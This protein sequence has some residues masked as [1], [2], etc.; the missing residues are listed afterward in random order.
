MAP[1]GPRG[2][3]AVPTDSLA[4]VF[5]GPGNGF[6]L[7]RLPKPSLGPDELL[8]QV[9]CCTV[10][11][12]DLH[13]YAG[14]RETPLP[15]ILGHE[16][17]GRI[18]AWSNAGGVHD[19]A[20]IPLSIG[21]RVTW[22]IAASCGSCFFCSRHLPQ[23]CETLFKYGHAKIDTAH[24]LSGGFAEHCHLLPGTAI[25]RLPENLPDAVAAPINCATATVAAALRNGGGCKS[26]TV[27]VMGAG[28][29]GLT[30][31]AMAQAG[32]ASEIIACDIDSQRL[33]AAKQFG[34]TQTILMGPDRSTL[35]SVVL[36]T[37]DGK[38]ADLALELSGS[39]KAVAAGL[40]LIRIGGR[41]ML[42]GSVF[43]T[44]A[45]PVVPE[46][47][48]RQHLTVRGIHNYAPDDLA[49]SIAFMADHADHFPFASLVA[50]SFPLRDAEHAMAFA[51]EHKPHR[52][53]IVP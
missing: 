33:S 41:L 37:T 10:C 5:T 26:E 44:P 27:L 24:A 48:V 39:P 29:L 30:A 18:E 53:A 15:T 34:A 1:N 2:T 42:V 4:A 40:D 47:I 28:M 22:S 38:G 25:F 43:P 6:E 36:D 46:K 49:R 31:C 21:D 7:R 13:T 45:V 19:H 23:K 11:G 17:I 3:P 50:Q 16:V 35:E 20:G 14:K 9:T 12:S 51:L 52:V 32:G 8:V